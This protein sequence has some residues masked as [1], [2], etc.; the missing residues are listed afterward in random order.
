MQDHQTCNDADKKEEK[1]EVEEEIIENKPS[2]LC[3]S[4]TRSDKKI[5]PA[6]RC[7][8]RHNSDRQ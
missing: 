8:G 1:E 2:F 5:H 7:V 3:Y 4:R 6:L